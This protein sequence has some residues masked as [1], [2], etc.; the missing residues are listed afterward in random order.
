M[1]ENKTVDIDDFKREARIRKFKQKIE[2]A[3]DKYKD[4]VAEHPAESMA[5]VTAAFGSLIG[6]ARRYDRKKDLREQQRLRE[7]YIYDRSIGDYWHTRRK[8]TN[9]DKLE[10]ERRR[11]GGESLGDILNDM[12][13]LDKRR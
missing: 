9:G 2:E 6:L 11:R 8:L 4:L 5:L 1:D 10:I 3:V 7:E 13:L 12:G